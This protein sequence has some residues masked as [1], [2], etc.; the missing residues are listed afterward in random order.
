MQSQNNSIIRSLHL[1]WDSTAKQTVIN[2]IVLLLRS[3]LPALIV[4]LIKYYVDNILG[5]GGKTFLTTGMIVVISIIVIAILIDEL[6]SSL[7]NYISK[8]Q[9]YLL[10]LHISNLIHKQTTGLGLRFFEN[11]VYHDML[12]RATRDISWRPAGMIS[13]LAFAIR[14]IISFLAMAVIISKFSIAVI[15]VIPVAF[16]PVYLIKKTSTARIYES[17]KSSTPLLRQA[18]Y[19]SWLLTG[20]RPAREV[21]LFDLDIFFEGLFNRHFTEAKEKEIKVVRQNTLTD[22]ISALIKMLVFAGVI[23]YTT[24]SLI[25]SSITAGEMAMYLIA[26]RQAMIYMRDIVSGF[27]GLNESRLF[28]QDLFNFLDTESDIDNKKTTPLPSFERI[29]VR[30]ITFTYPGSKYPAINHIS[31]KL[32][33][34]EKL[35]IVGPNGSGKTTLVKLLC[36]LYDPEQGTIESGGTDIKAFDI[37]DYRRQYSVVFQ[38]FMLYYLSAL[39]NIAIGD[40]SNDINEERINA[41]AEKAGIGEFLSRLP[42]GYNTMLGHQTEGGRELSWGE[43]Q[44]IAIARALYREAPVVIFDEPSSSL[45]ADSEYE[46]FS[47]LGKII[48]DRTCILIS[49]RLSNVSFADRIIV[50]SDGMI[51]ETGTHDQLMAAKGRYYSMFVRQKSMYR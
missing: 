15:I 50:L 31:F 22:I 45:D 36:R 46:I 25:R 9:S 38:D 20:E 29:D 23:L 24:R 21:K 41:A 39:E 12:D 7:G 18:S 30:D 26:F 35:A 49:H 40:K 4:V 27:T 14:G 34:G 13:D 43:W 5:P 42:D 32:N 10:E 2:T 11:H 44:K 16:I 17:R 3:L 51:A 1:L 28:V 19:F 47:R 8:K 33:K 37:H 48:E 6:L